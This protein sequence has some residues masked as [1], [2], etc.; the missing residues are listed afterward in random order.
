MTIIILLE[1]L[2]EREN[3]WNKIWSKKVLRSY[4]AERT[5]SVMECARKTDRQQKVKVDLEAKIIT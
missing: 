1:E 5:D 2:K 4:E 3:F